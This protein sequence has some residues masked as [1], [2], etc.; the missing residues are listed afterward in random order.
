MTVIVVLRYLALR[1]I[2]LDLSDVSDVL[3]EE[4]SRDTISKANSSDTEC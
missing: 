1:K 3:G 2:F 4:Q